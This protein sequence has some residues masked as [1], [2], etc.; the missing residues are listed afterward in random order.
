M[1]IP[2][3]FASK[4]LEPTSCSINHYSQ[5]F[6]GRTGTRLS[7]QNNIAA[8]HC[9]KRIDRFIGNQRV[10]PIE[11]MRGIVEWLSLQRKLL[12]VSIDWVDLRRF[13]CLVLAARLKGRAIPLSH[14]GTING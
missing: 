10:E 12:L 11:A 5:S 6:F 8:K 3:S 1:L 9:I 2:S 4:N 7:Y 14:S 13:Q